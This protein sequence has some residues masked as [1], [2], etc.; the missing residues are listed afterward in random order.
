SPHSRTHCTFI[1]ATRATAP[2]CFCF[3][4]Y[5][6]VIKKHSQ[7]GAGKKLEI[8]AFISIVLADFIFLLVEAIQ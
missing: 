5:S 2:A 7:N 3:P 6:T 4:G 1:Y 8:M